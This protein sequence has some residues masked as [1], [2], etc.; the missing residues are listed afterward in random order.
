MQSILTKFLNPTDFKGARI[1]ATC[2]AGSVV[3]PF[4]HEYGEGSKAHALAAMMLVRKLGW[5]PT[6]PDGTHQNGYVGAWAA[7]HSNKGDAYTF[8]FAFG[9]SANPQW[10]LFDYT[11]GAVASDEE[12]PKHR[13]KS[14]VGG[15]QTE[16]IATGELIGPVFHGTSELWAWQAANLKGE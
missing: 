10:E 15:W 2:D 4:P 9:V 5:I 12:M 1:K 13:C 3:I 8:C 7:G 14:V 6:A 11:F 16:V